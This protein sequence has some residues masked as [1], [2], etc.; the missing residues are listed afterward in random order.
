MTYRE[1]GSEFDL[2]R[3][4]SAETGLASKDIAT[5]LC[6]QIERTTTGYK[7]NWAYLTIDN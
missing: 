7:C 2:L 3:R 6:F 5:T 1:K 4:E